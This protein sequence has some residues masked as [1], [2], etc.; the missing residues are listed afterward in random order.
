MLPNITR[1]T[2][3]LPTRII[4]AGPAKV[5]KSTFASGMPA[6]IFLRTEDGTNGMDIDAFDVLTS[7]DEA[8]AQLRALATEQHD[9]QTVVI[10]ALD[11]LERLIWP[12]VIERYNETAKKPVASIE[13]IE[14]AKG[15]ILALLYWQMLLNA[16]T[17]LRNKGMRICLICHTHQR[18]VT[19]PD[20]PEYE[21]YEPRIHHKALA[22]LVEWADLIGFACIE[23][24]T[25]E[26]DDGRIRGLSTGRRLLHCAESA[27]YVAGNR[28]GITASLNLAWPDLAQHIEKDSSNG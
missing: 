20:L 16:L 24:R 5:G 9:Y 10:D 4:V 6:P 13:S 17:Y 8:M 3:R 22:M 21:R 7:F 19:P 2:A 25:K 12:A 18:K 11:G 23:T 26:G 1:T 14:Y 15:Y 28:Y 27:A